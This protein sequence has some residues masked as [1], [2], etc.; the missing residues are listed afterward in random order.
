MPET[1]YNKKKMSFFQRVKIMETMKIA[2]FTMQ[3]DTKED[4]VTINLPSQLKKL[5]D[6]INMGIFLIPQNNGTISV[7]NKIIIHD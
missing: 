1:F 5:Y 2:Q 7:D 3:I 6:H 4:I